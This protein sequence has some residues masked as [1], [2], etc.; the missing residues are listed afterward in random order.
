MKNKIITDHEADALYDCILDGYDDI[1]DGA[2]NTEE[3]ELRTVCACGNPTFR[4]FNFCFDCLCVLE[5]K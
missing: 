4:D 3:M 2:I 1:R 5:E